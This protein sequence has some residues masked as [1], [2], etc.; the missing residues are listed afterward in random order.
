MDR[1]EEQLTQL[2]HSIE[3]MNKK[4]I[5][6]PFHKNGHD[7]CKWM[8]FEMFRRDLNNNLHSIKKHLPR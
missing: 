3:R 2:V 4:A 6:S 5:E 8:M 7:Q 1:I